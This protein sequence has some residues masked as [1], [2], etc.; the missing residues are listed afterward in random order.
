MSIKMFDFSELYTGASQ[1]VD[2]RTRKIFKYDAYAGKTKFP[3]VILSAPIPYSSDQAGALIGVP[4]PEKESSDNQFLGDTVNRPGV[5]GFRARII[6]P[7]SPHSFLPD[8]CATSISKK[9]PPN[10]KFKLISMHTLFLSPQDYS[11]P[12]G[13][14]LPVIGEVV[15]VELDN[16]QFGYNLEVGRF[17]STISK[18]SMYFNEQTLTEQSCIEDKSGFNFNSTVGD[19]SA[20]RA[21]YPECNA[22]RDG[23][24]KKWIATPLN[25]YAKIVKSRISNKTL[26]LSIIAI[27]IQEQGKGGKVTGYNYNRYGIMTDLRGGWGVG[28]IKCSVPST[29]GAGGTGDRREK[30]RWFA[31]F[32]KEEDGIDFMASHLKNRGF[33]SATTGEQWAKLHILKW[34]SPSDKQ[35][36]VN[37]NDPKWV[38]YRRKKATIWTTAKTYYDSA[39]V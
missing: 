12:S 25:E 3:A 15:L 4:K 32:E 36:R 6:G 30:N 17:V 38:N 37:S 34:L 24:T 33:A 26:A 5:F 18:P 1:L 8:P 35:E 11:I 23:I 14:I 7:N 27:A 20:V 16:A 31:A 22:D 9:L 13:E 2:E 39:T 21:E 19:T 10:S 29:E 28:L